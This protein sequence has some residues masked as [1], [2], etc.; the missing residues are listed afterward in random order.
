M[1]NADAYEA[2]RHHR[3]AAAQVGGRAAPPA[4]DALQPLHGA[5]PLLASRGLAPDRG[6]P[7]LCVPPSQPLTRPRRP[8]E[9]DAGDDGG[10]RNEDGVAGT[11]RVG[12]AFLGAATKEVFGALAA[13]GTS[14]EARVNSRKHFR[15]R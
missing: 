8:Q 6:R 10:L 4:A 13:A 5:G 11:K 3:V 2:Q 7:Q 9:A 15:E 12:D 1:G 14:V